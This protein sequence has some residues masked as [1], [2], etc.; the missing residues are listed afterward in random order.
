MKTYIIHVSDATEREAH[1]KSQI[2]NK[3]LN[4][5]FINDGDKKDLSES[6]LNKYFKGPLH[7]RSAAASCAYKHILAYEN[8]IA[9]NIDLALV[10]EDDIFLSDDFTDLLN[11][12]ILEIRQ[13]NL[14]NF[15]V[16]LEDSSLQYV[17]GSERK[18]NQLLYKNIYGRMTGAYLVDLVAV[19]KMMNEIEKNKC[20]DNIDWFHNRSSEKG[21]INMYWIH[22]TIATQGSL[23]G[24]IASLIDD[25]PF[26]V[27][28]IFAF[29]L[30]KR[31]KKVLWRL[32]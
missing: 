8:M 22:P 10:L 6:I 30:E 17:R 2:E 19:I 15:I 32:R 18:K 16:S 12:A 21:M 28:R 4:Y 20:G 31:Y 13:R 3:K 26:G 9:N 5:Q 11:K 23:T 25:K 14:K 29:Q 24:S 7:Q 27:F 1:I